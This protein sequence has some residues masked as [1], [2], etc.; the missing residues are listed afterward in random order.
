MSREGSTGGGPVITGPPSRSAGPVGTYALKFSG[1]VKHVKRGK[2]AKFDTFA[3]TGNAV[4]GRER[5]MRDVPVRPFYGPHGVF[6]T[7][8]SA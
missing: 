1:D 4:T 5:T 2:H 8:N 7:S 3:V 6:V